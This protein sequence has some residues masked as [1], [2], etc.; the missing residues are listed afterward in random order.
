MND[1]QEYNEYLLDRHAYLLFDDIWVEVD[2]DDFDDREDA[3]TNQWFIV[4]IE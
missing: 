2:F 1:V 4:A 3:P